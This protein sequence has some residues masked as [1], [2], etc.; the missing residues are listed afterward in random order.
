[1][2]ERKTKQI[3][4][5]RAELYNLAINPSNGICIICFG[6]IEEGPSGMR[7]GH[8]PHPVIDVG[9]CCDACNTMHVI[10]ERLRRI[11]LPG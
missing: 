4:R 9:R 8:N 5:L 6:D 11:G 3:D 10:P 7:L 1:M 2:S